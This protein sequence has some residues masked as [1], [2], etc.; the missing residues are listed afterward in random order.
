MTHVGNLAFPLKWS[1]MEKS[2]Y[3]YPILELS[4]KDC[5]VVEVI[6]DFSKGLWDII[7]ILSK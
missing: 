1:K 3:K 2:N 4:I 6:G 7:D 5:T